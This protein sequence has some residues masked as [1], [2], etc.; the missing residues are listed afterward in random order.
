MV[1]LHHSRLPGPLLESRRFRC[2]RLS[3]L[4]HIGL[5]LVVP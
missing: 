1:E 2:P 4:Q 5:Y 3:L